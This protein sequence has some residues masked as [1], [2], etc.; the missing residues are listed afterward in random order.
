MHLGVIISEEVADEPVRRD[1]ESL[2]KKVNGDHNLADTGSR[3]IL[4]QGALVSRKCLRSQEPFLNKAC[5]HFP[6][7]TGGGTPTAHAALLADTLFIH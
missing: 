1:I 2:M 3:H 4:A 5:R 7:R 6:Q